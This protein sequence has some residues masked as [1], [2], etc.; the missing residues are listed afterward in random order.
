VSWYFL[1]KE[2]LPYYLYS[3]VTFCILCTQVLPSVSC[4]LLCYL[5][6]LMYS[7]VTF[8]ILCVLRCYLLYLVYS[9]ARDHEGATQA[10]QGE[11]HQ[12]QTGQLLP[13]NR[14]VF[15]Y[16]ARQKR[17]FL[18]KT[19]SNSV[20][21]SVSICRTPSERVLFKVFESWSYFMP[22]RVAMLQNL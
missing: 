10:A 4:V 14:G 5:L 2:Y 12:D 17:F 8:C 13:S 9:G 19:D 1:S 3:G 21:C 6:Y 20:H 11:V 15:K 18:L 16:V 22:K 7:G